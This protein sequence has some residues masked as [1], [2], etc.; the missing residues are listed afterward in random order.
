MPIT[1]WEKVETEDFKKQPYEIKEKVISNYIEMMKEQSPTFRYQTDDIHEQVKQNL[2]APFKPQEPGVYSIE[3]MEGA[4]NV[5][6]EG[7]SALTGGVTKYI[8]KQAEKIGIT[9]E[10]VKAAYEWP[11]PTTEQMEEH[12]KAWS[13]VVAGSETLQAVA[14]T[15]STYMN[16][17]LANVPTGILGIKIPE[18]KTAI[19]SL[20]RGGAEFKGMVTGIP[21]KT[22]E[23]LWKGTEEAV[24]TSPVAMNYLRNVAHQSAVMATAMGISEIAPAIGESKTVKEA[25]NRVID[26]MKGGAIIGAAYPLSGVIPTAPLRVA[27]GVAALDLYR[28]KGHFGIDDYVKDI[29]TGVQTN[30]VTP[31]LADNTFNY[32]MDIFFL[33]KTPSI[34]NKLAQLLPLSNT[35]KLAKEQFDMQDKMRNVEGAKQT[36]AGVI[37]KLEA[38]SK[39][40]ITAFE[41]FNKAMEKEKQ[42]FADDYV[43]VVEKMTGT[44]KEEWLQNIKSGMTTEEMVQRKNR[45][46]EDITKYT[47]GLREQQKEAKKLPGRLETAEEL[48]KRG[49]E[50]GERW[51]EKGRVKKLPF[52]VRVADTETLVQRIKDL[53]KSVL[54]AKAE[55]DAIDKKEYETGQNK[56]IEMQ[57]EEAKKQGESHAIYMEKL[58]KETEDE[59]QRRIVEFKTKGDEAS[60]KEAEDIA[61]AIKEAKEPPEVMEEEIPVREQVVPREGMITPAEEGKVKMP[62]QPVSGK[63]EVETPTEVPVKE[64]VTKSF[65]PETADQ[66]IIPLIEQRTKVATTK[67]RNI[68]TKQID[69]YTR[70]LMDAMEAR[71][72]DRL[73]GEGDKLVMMYKKIQQAKRNISPTEDK[74]MAIAEVLTSPEEV[75]DWEKAIEGKEPTDAELA[76]LE[77]E[78]RSVEE[79]DAEFKTQVEE[80][81]KPK[82]IGEVKIAGEPKKQG[83]IISDERLAAANE[84]FNRNTLHMNP[85]ELSGALI[86]SAIGWM[87]RTKVG[88][89]FYNWAN[90]VVK[91]VGDERIRPY[92]H[93]AWKA[94]QEQKGYADKVQIQI[95]QGDDILGDAA[96]PAKIR[97]GQM[98]ASERD[99]NQVRLTVVDLP[100][101]N[102]LTFGGKFL[103]FPRAC[104]IMQQLNPGTKWEELKHKY[105]A[106]E[107][108]KIVSQ[109]INEKLVDNKLKEIGGEKASE[110]IGIFSISVQDGGKEFLKKVGIAVPTL[111]PKE[112]A[113]YKW[114]R[115][116]YEAWFAKTNEMMVKNGLKPIAY[117]ADYTT[118]WR[119]ENYLRSHRK[120]PLSTTQEVYEDAIKN[121]DFRNVHPNETS[122]KFKKRMTELGNLDMD[123][124]GILRRYSNASIKHIEFTP[125]ASYINAIYYP[126]AKGEN[127]DAAKDP[128]GDATVNKKVKPIS[129]QLQTPRWAKELMEMK[130]SLLGIQPVSIFDGVPLVKKG[131]SI[132]R[133]NIVMNLLSFSTRFAYTQVGS[134][135]GTMG[136]IGGPHAALGIFKAM[137]PS[138]FKRAQNI[139]NALLPRSKQVDVAIKDLID[140]AENKKYFYLG[141]TGEYYFKT[142]ENISEFGTKLGLLAD[143]FMATAGWL[144]SESHAKGI[145]KLQDERSIMEYADDIIIKTQGSGLPGHIAPIQRTQE[146]R[147]GTTLQTFTINQWGNI[148]HDIV[149]I[150]NPTISKQQAFKNVAWFII[151]WQSLNFLFEDLMHVNT[152][153]PTPL[154]TFGFSLAQGDN[155]GLAALKGAGE[156]SQF[157]PVIS[158]IKYGSSIFGAVGDTLISTGQV[159]SDNPS[160]SSA[161]DLAGKFLG[162]PGGSQMKKS[163]RQMKNPEANLYDVL[164]G[165]YPKQ[166]ESMIMGI[167]EEMDKPHKA[168]LDYFEQIERDWDKES[169]KIE[170][171][172]EGKF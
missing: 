47:E 122:F 151:G 169:Q 23:K 158:G 30:T 139:S 25:T 135:V 94:A 62:V 167:L 8:S 10:N 70:Q 116:Q 74:K 163:Y 78:G 98:I 159:L 67:E 118:L 106:I 48:V 108:Q 124:F 129:L 84:K 24:K 125:F 128:Y 109:L 71:Y 35:D 152:V 147:T 22:A 110:H 20:A 45:V 42:G 170:R 85:V 65:T 75:K 26:S 148:I 69:D 101:G 51:R 57:K 87:E 154:R 55:A 104:D 3:N 36:K 13:T 5:A 92:L 123:A 162:I 119:V 127:I 141:K 143:N 113:G 153:M 21:F 73:P 40:D 59:A 52:E 12:P 34:K 133:N 7:L 28:N 86:E 164:M 165:T 117:R 18:S 105:N 33:T 114:L 144:G 83:R 4:W 58:I 115:S 6:K 60:K 166:R 66:H 130:D 68:L 157:M 89:D 2:L 15:L 61:K 1:P 142:K 79:I 53:T 131:M 27:V 44:T 168:Q 77:S 136:M 161:L 99:M 91:K 50:E 80:I 149:G 121:V 93:K 137:N 96:I 172:M 88:T 81:V 72:A 134:I 29:I 17:A 37:D 43:K 41:Q 76:K 97:K 138:E 64:E 103:N 156:L 16:A 11:S 56:F 126:F 31:E 39:T 112:M 120:D 49:V 111:T 146:G 132:L 63:S 14:N 82:K 155:I 100:E 38:L 19:E 107:K 145:L 95:Q 54:D 102:L 140:Y 32:V 46:D 150:K 9:P 160:R 90:D 171:G